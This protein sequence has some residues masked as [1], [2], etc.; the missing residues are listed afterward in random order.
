MEN[1]Q[2]A[3]KCR[4]YHGINGHMPGSNDIQ[5]DGQTC[6]CGKLLFYKERCGCPSNVEPT[7]TL[8][9]KENPNYIPQ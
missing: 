8:H 3:E 9:S 7:Y 4:E 2:Q 5:F 1:Q 6:D